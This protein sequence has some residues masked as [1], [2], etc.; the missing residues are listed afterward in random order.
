MVFKNTRTAEPRTNRQ[1]A[2]ASPPNVP[3]TTGTTLYAIV[4]SV[5][6]YDTII[7]VVATTCFTQRY[8]ISQK[9]ILKRRLIW[10]KRLSGEK[11]IL[12]SIFLYLLR[13]RVSLSIEK[14]EIYGNREGT[15]VG[16]RDTHNR[17]DLHEFDKTLSRSEVRDSNYSV[18]IF[19][20]L[21]CL[22]IYQ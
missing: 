6:K 14:K 7:V 15:M 18:S 9:W 12:S 4:N 22:R 2:S 11:D 20:Q 1:S 19:K 13:D 16:T 3:A 5:T 21:I 10:F 8:R 17:C